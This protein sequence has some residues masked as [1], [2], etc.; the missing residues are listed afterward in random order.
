MQLYR[1]STYSEDVRRELLVQIGELA[2]ITGWIASDA[3]RYD[4]A[5]RTYALGISAAR[6]AGDGPL[7]GN[8]AG[9]LAY[10]H[11]N[12]GREHDGV[13]LAQAALEEAGPG[14]PAKTRALFYDRI[15]WAHTR[16]GEA[17]S[18]PCGRSATR[19]TRFRPPRTTALRRGPTG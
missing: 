13:A 15:A 2:Q 12:T 11:A 14:A 19:T 18:R 9:S 5:A 8:L 6:Q 7:L 3:G 10:Q 16:A 4:E 1:E 17:R